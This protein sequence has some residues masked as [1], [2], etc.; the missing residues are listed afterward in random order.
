[1]KKIES[2]WEVIFGGVGGFLLMVAAIG[3]FCIIGLLVSSAKATGSSKDALII[4]AANVSFWTIVL[5]IA[6]AFA[7]RSDWKEMTGNKRRDNPVA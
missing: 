6:A 4:V 5:L 1:M 7:I 3:I 2:K